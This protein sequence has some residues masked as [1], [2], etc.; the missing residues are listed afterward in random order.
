MCWKAP[1]YS[2]F[3]S[4]VGSTTRRSQ[5]NRRERKATPVPFLNC[6]ERGRLR[7][8][9]IITL[10]KQALARVLPEQGN[11]QKKPQWERGPSLTLGMSPQ[12]GAGV[13]GG[14]RFRGAGL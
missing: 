2:A 11:L 8:E 14:P 1:A 6:V 9:F 10:G 5:R 13:G 3:T 12:S 7:T 4:D